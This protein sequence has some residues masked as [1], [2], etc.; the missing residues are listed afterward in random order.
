M[1]TI[2]TSTRAQDLHA[3]YKKALPSFLNPYY[4]QPI[5]IERGQGSYVWD[6]D[7]NR[8]LDFFGGVLTTM[9]GH[10]N[11]AVTA[12][13]QAQAAKVMHTSTLY[14][15]EPMIALA[16][17]IAELSGIPDARVFLT[18]SG[19]DALELACM[20]AGVGPVALDTRVNRLERDA[21]GVFTLHAETAGQPTRWRARGIMVSARSMPSGAFAPVRPRPR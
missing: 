18:P 9:V 10:N 13:V 1:T 8:Y 19:T 16:E 15:S 17:K 20:A 12:A 11:P 5:S 2:D 6:Q 21:Q 3:R 7:D 4:A 14:L